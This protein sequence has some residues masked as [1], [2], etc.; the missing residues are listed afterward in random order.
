M[1]EWSNNDRNYVV[2]E[3]FVSHYPRT[4]SSR[5]TNNR[6]SEYRRDSQPKHPSRLA[7]VRRD[8]LK[9]ADAT[10]VGRPNPD[11]SEHEIVF[12]SAKTH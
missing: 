2:N 6:K 11:R 5:L 3:L 12:T 4:V 10:E 9:K 1:C 7:C 8:I